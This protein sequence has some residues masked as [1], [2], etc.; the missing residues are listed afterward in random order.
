MPQPGTYSMPNW[1]GSAALK[2]KIVPRPGT[3]ALLSAVFTVGVLG[4]IEDVVGTAALMES[5]VATGNTNTV[6]GLEGAVI[7]EA[8]ESIAAAGEVTV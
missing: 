3:F 5:V 2:L 7:L 1:A 8:V 6:I 4:E